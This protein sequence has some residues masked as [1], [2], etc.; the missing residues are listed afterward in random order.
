MQRRQDAAS[1]GQRRS[2]STQKKRKDTATKI[3]SLNYE[4]KRVARGEQRVFLVVEGNNLAF[5]ARTGN[6]QIRLNVAWRKC[7]FWLVVL[8]R[9]WCGEEELKW[10]M[11]ED[12]RVKNTCIALT[13]INQK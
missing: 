7:V 8:T 5:F 12:V 4:Q 6:E 3:S 11:C 13:L 2:P 9:E 10:K 1:G